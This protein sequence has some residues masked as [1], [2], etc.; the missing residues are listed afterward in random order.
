MSHP[1]EPPILRSRRQKVSPQIDFRHHEPPPVPRFVFLFF[2]GGVGEP[3]LNVAWI[4]KDRENDD[5]FFSRKK[6]KKHAEDGG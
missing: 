3:F 2:W 5:F 6:K 1:S 4:M